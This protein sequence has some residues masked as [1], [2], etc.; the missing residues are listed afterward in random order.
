MK[1][2]NLS[3]MLPGDVILSHD[4]TW[5][6]RAIR[7]VTSLQTGDAHYSHAAASVGDKQIIE[8]LWQITINDA[9]KYDKADI[10]VIRLP[11]SD[12]ERKDFR[13][14]MLKMAG[15]VYGLTK[16]FCFAG[17]AFLTRVSRLWGNK[18]PV[19]YCMEHYGLS[20]RPVCSE[21]VAYGLETF[22]SHQLKD[23][24]LTTVSWKDISPDYLEDLL[25]LAINGGEVIFKQEVV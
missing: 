20:D 9:S 24:D 23:I 16:L 13:R 3:E 18:K 1:I 12:Q 15:T 19:F 25:K 4:G 7:W 8:A 11:L 2:S 17:D 5:L 14:G 6:S 22:T 10:E 21:L